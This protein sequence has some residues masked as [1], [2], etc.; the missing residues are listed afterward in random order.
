M[1]IIDKIS[2]KISSII[3]KKVLV[4]VVDKFDHR[5]VVFRDKEL[6]SEGIFKFYVTI[7]ERKSFCGIKFWSY[8]NM[9]SFLGD[10]GSYNQMV[11]NQGL[12]GKFIYH[13]S[14]G[15]TT[16]TFLFKEVDFD[17]GAEYMLKY[18]I[19]KELD[20]TSSEAIINTEVINSRY[21]SFTRESRLSKILD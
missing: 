1:N 6:V 20:Y 11:I 5:F 4:K 16:P 8:Y 7:K 2:Y 9:G 13:Y 19:S 15:R 17:L 10:D 18:K 3:S 14:F 21:K 12:E